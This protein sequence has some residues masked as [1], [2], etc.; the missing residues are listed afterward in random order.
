MRTAAC[1]SLVVATAVLAASAGTAQVPASSP[2]PGGILGAA[3]EVPADVPGYA[4]TVQVEAIAR[5]LKPVAA[6]APEAQEMLGAL[7]APTAVVS[8][9]YLAQDLSR[10]EIVSTDF[11]LP[12]G[13]LLLHRAGDKAYVVADPGTK[14]YAVM[15]AEA[16]LSALEGGAGIVNSQYSA[17]VLHTDDRKVIA[18]LPARKSIVTVSYVTSLPLENDRILVQQKND[19]EIWHTSGLSSAAAMDHFFFKFQRDKTGEVRRAIAADIGFPL[20]VKFVVTQ[21][22]TGPKAGTIQP[23]SLHATVT[24]LKKEPKL[25]A[26]LFRIPPAGYRR[27]DR[28]PFFGAA[29]ARPTGKD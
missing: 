10:Q 12:A 21:A 16:L 1:C 9:F 11:V 8:R 28:L 7:K 27:V 18:G 14:T 19:I 15:D 20:E 2:R 29:A 13:T 3:P 5:E 25:E 26:S 23:G 4:V 22:G 6:T 17:K 24:E